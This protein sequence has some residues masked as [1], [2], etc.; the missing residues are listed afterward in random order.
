MPQTTNKYDVS[1]VPLWWIDEYQH[2]QSTFAPLTALMV[3]GLAL[4]FLTPFFKFGAFIFISAYV[5][6]KS[7]NFYLMGALD[8]LLAIIKYLRAENKRD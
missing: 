8:L 4:M 1:F 7:L 5:A 2:I 3:Y 6:K